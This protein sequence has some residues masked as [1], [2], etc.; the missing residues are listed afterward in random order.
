MRAIIEPW[1]A[2][3]RGSL[4]TLQALRDLADR[5]LAR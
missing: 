4:E 5:V 3:R 1:E 2:G